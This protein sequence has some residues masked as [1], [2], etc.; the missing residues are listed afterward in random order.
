[1]TETL[2]R[3]A[4][5]RLVVYVDDWSR[6]QGE[7]DTYSLHEVAQTDLQPG[8]LFESLGRECG[9]GRPLTLDEALSAS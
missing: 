5:D 4:D 2:Y 1:M 8:G 6:W 9:F 3:T 7:P